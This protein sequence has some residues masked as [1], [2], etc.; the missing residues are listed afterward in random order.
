MVKV[1]ISIVVYARPTRAN[2]MF[3]WAFDLTAL[4]LV[5]LAIGYTIFL[6]W[7]TPPGAEDPLPGAAVLIDRASPNVTLS[8]PQGTAL[9]KRLAFAAS[10]MSFRRK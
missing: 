3:F 5:A 6:D 1:P 10:F 4:G 7:F 8:A 2:G 9:T